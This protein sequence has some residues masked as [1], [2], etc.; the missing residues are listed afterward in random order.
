MCIHTSTHT[1]PFTWCTPLVL[2]VRIFPPIVFPCL[3]SSGIH[4]YALTPHYTHSFLLS[5]GAFRFRSEKQKQNTPPHPLLFSSPSLHGLVSCLFGVFWPGR[6]ATDQSL[7]AVGRIVQWTTPR[8]KWCSAH[9]RTNTHTRAPNASEQF[10]PQIFIDDRGGDNRR[11]ISHVESIH[12]H[13]KKKHANEV[14]DG[15]LRAEN[16]Q[17]RW[18]YFP[19]V[20]PWAKS[21]RAWGGENALEAHRIKKLSYTAAGSLTLLCLQFSLACR[22]YLWAVLGFFFIILFPSPGAFLCLLGLSKKKNNSSSCALQVELWQ[23]P[24]LNAGHN[25]CPHH[26]WRDGRL[27]RFKSVLPWINALPLLR[28]LTHSRRLQ[29]RQARRRRHVWKLSAPAR[30][31]RK[32]WP[33]KALE[34]DSR[35]R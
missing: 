8:G 25:H 3:L 19:K 15:E 22:V 33:R 12:T 27:K 23:K 35:A 28:S 10:S 13:G 11:T 30:R 29:S 16:E 17:K 31:V 24:G 7:A 18:C 26:S 32:A 14:R 2:F 20:S 5:T 4:S 9:A 34:R 1:H 21:E 6:I